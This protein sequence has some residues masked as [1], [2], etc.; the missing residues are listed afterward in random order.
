M[1]FN[2]LRAT[3]KN[4]MVSPRLRGREKESDISSGAEKIENFIIDKIGGA[5]KRGGI[6]IP[7]KQ[8][9]V[10]NGNVGETFDNY[11][12]SSTANIK[13]FS[14][15][16]RGEEVLL[17][18]NAG[19][20]FNSIANE[21]DPRLIADFQSKFLKVM[22]VSDGKYMDV[23]PFAP[24][25]ADNNPI[26]TV[27]RD[28]L[29]WNNEASAFYRGT[30]LAD[31]LYSQ[32]ITP[33][34]VTKVSDA[35]VVFTSTGISFTLS[36]LDLPTSQ[37]SPTTSPVY[38]L[39]PYFVNVRAFIVNLGKIPTDTTYYN[40][41]QPINFPFNAVNTNPSLG[42]RGT[43]V[44]GSGSDI[45]NGLLSVPT[46]KL[47][48]QVTVLQAMCLDIYTS[49]IP[50]S[51]VLVGKF[52]SIPDSSNVRDIVFFIT[53]FTGDI[54]EVTFTGSITGT[55]LT[56]T[57]SNPPVTGYLTVDAVIYGVGVAQGTK[58]TAYGTGVGGTG[59][60]TISISQTVSSNEMKIGGEF[61]Y[62]A[63]QITGGTPEVNSTR[64][65]VSTFGGRSH[66]KIV[67][68]CFER[69]L[70]G[71][72]GIE[73]AKWWASG[74]HPNNITNFQ[75]FLGNSL[76]QDA[77]SDVSKMLYQG[78]S[79]SGITDIYRY[80]YS[81][82]VPNLSAISYIQSRRRI[83][84]G[85]IDGECQLTFGKGEFN[86]SS[87]EQNIVRS[88]SSILSPASAGDGKFFYIGNYGKEIRYVSTEDKDYESVDGLV[89]TAL[90]GL[91]IN[92]TKI[93]WY[94]KL[95]TLICMCIDK[96]I[97][98]VTLHE[99]TQIKAVTEF[100]S[101]LD[102]VDFASSSESLYFLY[103]YKGFKHVSR[104]IPTTN[105]LTEYKKEIELGGDMAAC[106]PSIAGE[107]SYTSLFLFFIGED[108]YLYYNGVEYTIS[109]PVGYDG[110]WASIVLPVDISGATVENP[111]FFYGKKVM[112]K[113]KTPPITEG[114]G[115]DSAVGDTIRIDRALIQ[116]DV[117][118]P[119]RIGNEGGTI[120][121]AEGVQLKPLSTKFIKYD[122]PQSPDI[123]NHLY[124]ET[125]KP[126]PLNISGVAYRGVS[127]SGA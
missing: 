127:N 30:G 55:T 61:V 82:I 98:F 36:L 16:L 92:F 25:G 4:G 21:T 13:I 79:T 123:E 60:Y 91:D 81:G 12:A 33:T 50:D 69:L 68:Y 40:P 19:I 48:T 63:I 100:K 78:I 93:L 49:P 111:A 104:Y 85:T 59:T 23:R 38:V 114:G 107:I 58:I 116:V 52:L 87:V 34:Q 24:Y 43:T 45:A 28:L 29:M 53:K 72:A 22:R 90:E 88:N 70:Y 105:S 41:I 119:F 3:F 108:I 106:Y 6:Q 15:T 89:T 26:P 112:A 32:I 84:F 44:T 7:F 47:V 75:G 80:G 121:D 20:P 8:P 27:N 94:E 102:I 46:N 109:I 71:N 110:T 10:N 125:D 118:G 74:F 73:K 67:A 96:R 95:S 57:S 97:L 62:T 11:S 64:W 37:G 77:T 42:I 113:I 99:D 31:Y 51:Q 18:F 65:K 66:P 76:Q 117:S 120:Y 83:H 2:T 86:S 17:S 35:T 103:N 54:G 39:L 56:V 1:K 122:M 115:N 101:E 126:T 5:V 14:V 9:F 124:I